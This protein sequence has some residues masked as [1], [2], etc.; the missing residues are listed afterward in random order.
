MSSLGLL[1]A[2]RIFGSANCVATSAFEIE[3]VAFVSSLK[4]FGKVH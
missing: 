4:K 1:R 2:E 3:K